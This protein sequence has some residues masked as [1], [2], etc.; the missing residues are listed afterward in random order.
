MPN[1]IIETITS[2]G[3]SFLYFEGMNAETNQLL[4]NIVRS[5]IG[6]SLSGFYLQIKV[7][8]LIYLPLHKLSL[9]DSAAYLCYE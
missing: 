1:T 6:D 7:L 5:N 4:E 2:S 8:E 3:N 9:R